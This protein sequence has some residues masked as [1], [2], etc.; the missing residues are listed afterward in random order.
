S[1][2]GAAERARA[3][4]L[5]AAPPSHTGPDSVVVPYLPDNDGLGRIAIRIGGDSVEATIDPT[6]RGLLLDSAWMRRPGIK[7]FGGTPR[8]V[9]VVP[10]VKIDALAMTNVGVTFGTTGSV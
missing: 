3:E 2:L 8:S 5:R 10:T 4:W 7:S 6:V 1:P 9:G